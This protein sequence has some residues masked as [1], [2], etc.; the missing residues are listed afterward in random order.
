MILVSLEGHT[1]EFNIITYLKTE[2]FDFCRTARQNVNHIDLYLKTNINCSE[3][4][5]KRF[6]S[7]VRSPDLFSIKI[8]YINLLSNHYLKERKKEKTGCVQNNSKVTNK[9][10]KK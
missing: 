2:S 8:L 6:E 9:K 5:K 1:N 10:C 4:L 3:N 7:F